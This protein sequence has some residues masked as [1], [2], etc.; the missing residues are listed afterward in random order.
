MRFIVYPL[1]FV[2]CLV[3]SPFASAEVGSGINIRE[4]WNTSSEYVS[5]VVEGARKRAKKRTNAQR[6]SGEQE[7]RL[8][9]YKAKGQDISSRY[10]DFDG[11]CGPANTKPQDKAIVKCNI[12]VQNILKECGGISQTNYKYRAANSEEL[13]FSNGFKKLD[14]L[15]P[16]EAP[17]GAIILS[18]Y[19]CDPKK[20]S[21][22]IEI[23]VGGE[24]QCI[25]DFRQ[26]KCMGGN[27]RGCL[28]EVIGIYFK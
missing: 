10:C 17:L 26:G 16:D 23:K 15:N 28:G 22:H 27:A 20:A 8:A 4:L 19:T 7:Q 5:G 9:C 12:Y 2:G 18:R 21:G 1:L 3:F 11:I 25:S 24:D 13:L 6:L 14:T